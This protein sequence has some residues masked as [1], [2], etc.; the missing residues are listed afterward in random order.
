MSVGAWVGGRTQDLLDQAGLR[1]FV[2]DS[3]ILPVAVAI[4]CMQEVSGFPDKLIAQTHK[5]IKAA[6]VNIDT[7]YT[8]KRGLKVKPRAAQI[9]VAAPGSKKTPTQR[10][11][12]I[13]AFYEAVLKK[14]PFLAMQN[15]EAGGLLWEGGNNTGFLKQLRLQDGY[16]LMLVE[17]LVNFFD[18]SYAQ[19]GNTNTNNHVLP[20]ALLNLRT[21]NGLSKAI[22]SDLENKLD[23]SQVAMSFMSQEDVVKE[24]FSG[25]RMSTGFLQGFEFVVALCKACKWDEIA[26]MQPMLDFFA[27]LYE[28]MLR[29]HGHAAPVAGYSTSAAAT[30]HAQASFDFFE[31]EKQNISFH[32]VCVI[33]WRSTRSG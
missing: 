24:V 27:E 5:V 9:G 15:P 18:V 13:D 14:L 31:D 23:K 30:P 21:G 33:T 3:V 6:C 32:R 11:L 22:S 1:P 2:Q 7:V 26:E 19:T 29:L 10:A 4:Y 20:T 12:I 8:F 17:E 16:L 25:K 28:A